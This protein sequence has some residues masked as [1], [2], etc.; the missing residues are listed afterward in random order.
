MH[1]YVFLFNLILPAV[2][3]YTVGYLLYIGFCTCLFA[4]TVY[5]GDDFIVVHNILILIHC[6]DPSRRAWQPTPVLLPGES[7]W[8]L[9]GLQCVG[10]QSQTSL[11]E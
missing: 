10:S 1:K 9:V 3:S 2:F 6:V 8:S 11:S 7:P 5:P 4:L